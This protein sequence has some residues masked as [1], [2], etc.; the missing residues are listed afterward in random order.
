MAVEMRADRYFSGLLDVIGRHGDAGAHCRRAQPDVPGGEDRIGVDQGQGAG[1][2]D[3]IG[4][5]DDKPAGQ[6]CGRSRDPG[7][8]LDHS[9][10]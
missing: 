2:M 8:D 3:G 10:G 6:G 1:E 9:G 7:G 5:T 4:P